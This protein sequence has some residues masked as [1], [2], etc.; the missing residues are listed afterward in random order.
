MAWKLANTQY[1]I[2]STLLIVTYIPKNDIYL[3][4]RDVGCS[5]HYIFGYN[6]FYT[7]RYNGSLDVKLKGRK[8]LLTREEIR[9]SLYLEGDVYVAIIDDFKAFSAFQTIHEKSSEDVAG[10]ES[11]VRVSK[12]NKPASLS[13]FFCKYQTRYEEANLNVVLYC[14][15][16]RNFAISQYKDMKL[17]FNI[18]PKS[19]EI[20]SS[21]KERMDLV[22][23]LP[24]I[25]GVSHSSLV[26]EITESASIDSKLFTLGLEEYRQRGWQFAVDDYG[27]DES[28]LKRISDV[29]PKYVKIDRSLIRRHIED[30]QF[31]LEKQIKKIRKGNVHII[32]EGVENEQEWK[33]VKKITFDLVQGFYFSMPTI[34]SK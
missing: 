24:S 21:D 31:D 18:T 34:F 2:I 26:A 25:L 15:H 27:M 14:L 13:E 5:Q 6:T 30:N 10:V 19:L 9:N 4:W 17:F 20:V 16:L 7:Q 1:I 11:L 3:G 12:E 23:L 8:S 32:M 28:N 29:K 22:S 33:S